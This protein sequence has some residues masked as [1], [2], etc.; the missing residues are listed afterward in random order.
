M[1]VQGDDV[2]SP[3]G[4]GDG[5]GRVDVAEV[6][7]FKDYVRCSTATSSCRGHCDG[8]V[9][10]EVSVIHLVKNYANT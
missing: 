9:H 7:G 8:L 1:A 10:M 3:R 5:E 2:I 6:G 4:G